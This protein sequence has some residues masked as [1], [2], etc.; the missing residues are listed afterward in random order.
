MK[1]DPD[2]FSPEREGDIPKGAYFP[3]GHG[4]RIC[5]GQQLAMVQLPLIAATMLQRFHFE[6]QPGYDNLTTHREMAIRPA[7][8]CP[9]KATRREA[10]PSRKPR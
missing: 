10:L 5:I 9:V 6:P 7:T 4:P 3:F 8:P 2:R 1:F